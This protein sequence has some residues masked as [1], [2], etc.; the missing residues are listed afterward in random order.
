MIAMTA[1]VLGTVLPVGGCPSA[2]CVHTL[3]RAS[4]SARLGQCAKPSGTCY[5]VEEMSKRCP[6]MPVAWSLSMSVSEAMRLLSPLSHRQRHDRF[7]YVETILG[8][9]VNA[10]ARAGSHLVCDLVTTID[11]HGVREY[12]VVCQLHLLSVA[13]PLGML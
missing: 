11:G 12:G 3:G 9:V 5:T 13:N 6:L 4:H 7:L 10:G 8:D 1:C 2:M